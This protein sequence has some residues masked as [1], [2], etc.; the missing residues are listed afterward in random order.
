MIAAHVT[1]PLDVAPVRAAQL[2]E[3]RRLFVSTASLKP[4]GKPSVVCI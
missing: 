1:M 2:M 3:Q 4:H